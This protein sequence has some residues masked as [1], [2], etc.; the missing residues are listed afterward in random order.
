VDDSK[1]KAR[2]FDFILSDHG[3][4]RIKLPEVLAFRNFSYRINTEIRRKIFKIVRNI[5]RWIS[6][7]KGIV[8]LSY[9]KGEFDKFASC[10][11]KKEANKVLL[12]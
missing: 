10:R 12:L 1:K 9:E 4:E 2:L 8:K 3:S 11:N 5:R 6:L 7:K